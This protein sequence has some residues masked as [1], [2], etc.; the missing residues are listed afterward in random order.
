MR[1]GGGKR[2]AWRWL[3]A[4][5]SLVS[6]ADHTEEDAKACAGWACSAGTCQAGPTGPVCVC[7]AFEQ[8]TGLSCQLIQGDSG[9]DDDFDH[10]HPIDLDTEVSGTI[11]ASTSGAPQDFD[12]YSIDGSPDRV[13][14]VDATSGPS[15][16]IEL[17]D[18][19]Y[20]VRGRASGTVVRLGAAISGPRAYVRVHSTDSSQL[21][22]YSF[23][24][25]DLA[26]SDVDTPL[27]PGS[28]AD[29]SIAPAD[30][31]DW[32][33]LVV[34][35]GAVYVVDCSFDAPLVGYVALGKD[36][37]IST[38]AVPL[39]F[40]FKAEPGAAYAAVITGNQIGT[41]HCTLDQAPDDDAGDRDQDARPLGANDTFD[42]RVDFSGDTD[43]FAVPA[44]A[45]TSLWA[46]AGPCYVYFEQPD[47]GSQ[48]VASAQFTTDQWAFVGPRSE[49]T[50]F[51][52]VACQRGESA[53][54]L[55]TEEL[56]D[57]EGDDV[58]A[59]VNV[60]P[61]LVTGRFDHPGDRDVFRLQADAHR[62][63]TLPRST[64]VWSAE[65]A[66]VNTVQVDNGDRFVFSRDDD[67]P[68]FL[69]AAWPQLLDFYPAPFQYS[70]PLTELDVVDA[71]P[72]T[73]AAAIDIP[74]GPTVNAAAQYPGDVDCFAFQVPAGVP[75]TVEVTSPYFLVLPDGTSGPVEIDP[76][77][78]PAGPGGR[79]VVCAVNYA[80]VNATLLE[81]PYT[82]RVHP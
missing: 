78:I 70:D 20:S 67:G 69:V 46:G 45:G 50:V 32:L 72:G 39:P 76:T 10:A 25:S 82:V 1:S 63:Y 6:C 24:V 52:V 38:P 56:T 8:A 35:G 2:H 13:Y 18:A 22:D 74:L 61:G 81:M 29:R 57:A 75:E 4:V 3:C 28:R 41:Y 49:R 42:G 7:G 79:R 36:G 40:R 65:G 14:V 27:A 11:G 17:I 80:G 9:N 30:E 47:D 62:V 58:S 34:S 43:V 21:G 59:A 71:E 66:G 37:F 55:V 12:Y 54:H 60:S 15:L 64:A 77:V 51:L 16:S 44:R 19:D 68:I 73:P 53:Y 31:Y 33:A 23:R 5:V 48:T 26:P